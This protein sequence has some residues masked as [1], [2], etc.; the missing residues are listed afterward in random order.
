VPAVLTPDY[1]FR[2]LRRSPL[3][4]IEVLTVDDAKAALLKLRNDA[5]LYRAM[6][7]NGRLRGRD[8]T[9]DATTDRWQTL[10][11][12]TLPPLAAAIP[13]WHFGRAGR[14]VLRALR[15]LRRTLTGTARK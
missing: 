15:K 5:G 13:R 4:Y 10:L 6:V 14:S 2:E 11:Y 7:D 9:A 1:A 8:F 3:D 12:E